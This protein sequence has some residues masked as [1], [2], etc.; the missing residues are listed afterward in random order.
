MGIQLRSRLLYSMDMQILM[1]RSKLIV[2][3]CASMSKKNYACNQQCK[4]SNNQSKTKMWQVLLDSQLTCNVIV[5]LVLVY[6]VRK[7]EWT[8][9][10]QSQEGD[11]RINNIIDISGVG[12]VQFCTNHIAS[13][14]SQHRMDTSS[15]QKI[16]CSTRTY[17]LSSNK[18]DLNNDTGTQEGIK[19]R[20]YPTVEG[21]CARKVN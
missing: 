5:N 12:A 2:K 21:L 16:D 10:L 14:L 9:R 6:N 13:I 7:C 11:C 19:C 1:L 3:K 4:I 18:N 20:F 8:L 17:C 15:N